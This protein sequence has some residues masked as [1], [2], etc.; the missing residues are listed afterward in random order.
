T[1]EEISQNGLGGA[2][3]HSATSGV[4]H[5]AYDDEESCLEDVRFLLSLLP[6]NNRELPP[7]T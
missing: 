1:G 2:D 4:S 6:A 5:F 7:A 3:V